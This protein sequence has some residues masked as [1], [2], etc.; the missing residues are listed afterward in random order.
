MNPKRSVSESESHAS[1]MSKRPVLGPRD[2]EL[3]QVG[4]GSNHEKDPAE[5]ETDNT[6]KPERECLKAKN[7]SKKEDKY[8]GR[9][10][11]HRC[12][13]ISCQSS[14]CVIHVAHCKTT[15]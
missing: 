7:E 13:F 9:R 15:A 6:D 5:N 12:K 14:I 2:L 4:F 1:R 3:F 10:F 8:K 11:T